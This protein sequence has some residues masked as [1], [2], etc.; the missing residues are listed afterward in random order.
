MFS[1]DKK[2][3][4]SL[5]FTL[6]AFL[7]LQTQKLPIQN[8]Q[9][10]LQPSRNNPHQKFKKSYH[11][12]LLVQAFLETIV[13]TDLQSSLVIE[14]GSTFTDIGRTYNQK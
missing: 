3:I 13:H 1:F 7:Q 10:C 6:A 9:A 5:S 12:S 8:F 14:F 11:G 2:I 4:K